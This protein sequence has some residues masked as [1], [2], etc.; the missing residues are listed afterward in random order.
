MSAPDS[1]RRC[2]ATSRTTLRHWLL[3]SRRLPPTSRSRTAVTP[4]GCDLSWSA[5]WRSRSGPATDDCV[6]RHGVD[7]DPTRVRRRYDVSPEASAKV[8]V[9]VEGR[10][11]Q[12]SNLEKILYPDANFAKGAVIDYYAKIAPVMLPHLAGRPATFKR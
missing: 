6:T 7:C 5:R 3:S 2:C 4:I 10:T 9:D 8:A 1:P 12:L 11:L